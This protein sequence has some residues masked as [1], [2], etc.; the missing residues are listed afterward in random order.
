MSAAGSLG[1][2]AFL[3]FLPARCRN[4]R[5]AS[6]LNFV[7]YMNFILENEHKTAE[8]RVHPMCSTPI[9]RLLLLLRIPKH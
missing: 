3:L 7:G 5:N 8:A 9:F 6:L 2:E 4:V 1:D